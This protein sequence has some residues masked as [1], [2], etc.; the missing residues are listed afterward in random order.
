MDYRALAELVWLSMLG[1]SLFA[2]TSGLTLRFV[3]KP[4]LT[5]LLEI[6]RDRRVTEGEVAQQLAR[7]EA[8]LVD[9]DSELERLR[10]GADFDRRLEASADTRS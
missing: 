7:I 8:Q 6:F 4:F 5:E 3:L 10:A 9:L 1:L 2:A